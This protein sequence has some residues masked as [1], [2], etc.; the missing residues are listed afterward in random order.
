MG[1]LLAVFGLARAL[2]YYVYYFHKESLSLNLDLVLI[3]GDRSACDI[4]YHARA[5]VCQTACILYFASVNHVLV[6][7]I[8]LLM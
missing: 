2:K 3:K 7:F 4:S 6:S 1:T 5:V 8:P